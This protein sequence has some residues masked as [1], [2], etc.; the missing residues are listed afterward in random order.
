V[1]GRDR[2]TR[3][4]LDLATE[5]LNLLHPRFAGKDGLAYPPAEADGPA[6]ARKERE[7]PFVREFYHQFRRLWDKA[8]P[9]RLGL[10]HLLIQP[11]PTPPPGRQPDLLVWQLGEHGAP[12]RRLAALAFVGGS[13]PA[14]LD[15]DLA[16][17]GRFLAAGYGIAVLVVIGPDA[18]PLS[19]PD[20]V[21]ILRFDPDR[22]QVVP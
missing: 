9:V 21:T 16:A 15:A 17:L 10:G 13:N 12:D 20:G 19:A 1:E 5:A 8:L 3:P 7:R 6:A 14:A 18:D 4:F 11:Y 22:W 2:V